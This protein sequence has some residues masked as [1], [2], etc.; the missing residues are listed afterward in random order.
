M[1]Q[2]SLIIILVFCMEKEVTHILT[3]Q[4][5]LMLDPNIAI[6]SESLHQGLQLGLGLHQQQR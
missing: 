4:L 5:S 6:V 1:R 3:H 2:R